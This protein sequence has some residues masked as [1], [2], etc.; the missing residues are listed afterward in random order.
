MK[1]GTGTLASWK[2]RST[3]SQNVYDQPP[4]TP[5]YISPRSPPEPPPGF[6]TSGFKSVFSRTPKSARSTV[7]LNSAYS[8]STHTSNLSDNLSLHPYAAMLPAPVPVVSSHDTLD[9]GDECP[10]CLEPL[11]FS[12]RLPGE[13]PHIVPECGHA[14]HEVHSKPFPDSLIV[15]LTQMLAHRPAS[16]PSMGHHR[17]KLGTACLEKVTWV[18]AASVDDR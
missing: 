4:L 7:S 8:A 9:D 1:T 6:T 15:P 13:K 2:S 12:F 17:I 14:L 5:T 18:C 16:A 10:V 3:Q 11:S